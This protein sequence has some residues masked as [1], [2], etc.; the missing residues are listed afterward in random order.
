[1]IHCAPVN[2]G[3][4]WLGDSEGTPDYV[5]NDPKVV[6][7]YLGVEEDEVEAAE[8]QVGS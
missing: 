4:A 2:E 7:A 8:A 3:P 1:M 6:A 5:R